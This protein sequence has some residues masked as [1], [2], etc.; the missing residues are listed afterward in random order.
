M[1]P[2]EG[3]RKLL[4]GDPARNAFK[5]CHHARVVDA[6][7]G[8]ETREPVKASPL[9][10]IARGA[11]YLVGIAAAVRL[12]EVVVGR[13]PLGAA[14][15]GAVIVDLATYRVG[16]RW[17]ADASTKERSWRRLGRG[18]ALGLGVALVLVVVPVAAAVFVGGAK[19]SLGSPSLS[20]AFALLRAAAVGTRD[21]LLYR[22]VPL[23]VAAR[24]GLSLPVAIGYGALVGSSALVLAPRV[25]W[26][27]VV[28]ALSEGVLFA[29][30]WVRT[31]AA[32]ASVAAHAGFLFFAGVG[33]RGGLVEVVWG[34]GLL[35]DGVRSRG[36]PAL[37]CAAV[38]LLL[39]AL[40]WKKL[41]PAQSSTN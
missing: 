23:A 16:V 14:L 36:L 6:P 25:S 15:V 10:E 37:V 19:I 4:Q 38:A 1:A 26:E 27:S 28:L 21:E 33:L 5:T 18:L 2:A 29:V 13:S 11:A 41:P 40:A 12:G 3:G 30:L 8:S 39:A 9:R 24:A 34:D 32:W 31:R 22:G 17:D 20:L 7:V 35:A